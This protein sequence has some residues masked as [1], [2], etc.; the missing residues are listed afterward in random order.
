[1]TPTPQ[2]FH[3]LT[4]EEI[5]TAL[6][7]VRAR[8]EKTLTYFLLAHFAF[9][10]AIA[11]VYDTWRITIAAG[12]LNLLAFMATVRLAPGT[13]LARIVSGVALQIFVAL[14]IYQFHGLAEMHFFF[15]TSFAAMIAYLDWV[16]MWPATLFIIV[17]HVAFA[18]LHNSGVQLYFFEDSYVG[19]TKLGMHF[20]IGVVHVT[21][22]GIWAHSLR[23]RALRDYAE[24]RD[25]DA[26]VRERT[27]ELSRTAFDLRV[28]LDN[29][30][31]GFVSVDRNGMLGPVHSEAVTAWFGRK[32]E[33]ERFID[34]VVSRDARFARAFELGLEA[35]FEDVLP[36]ELTLDQLPARMQCGDRIISVSYKLLGA[37]SDAGARLVVIL[38][39]CTAETERA[40]AE[41][42]QRDLVAAIDR[43]LR[44]KAGFLEFFSESSEL[45][46]RLA[47]GDGTRFLDEK[48]DLHTL[49]GNTAIYGL[50]A[51]SSFCHELENGIEL[52]GR[53]SL[54]TNARLDLAQR[55][56]TFSKQLR[57]LLDDSA[58][59]VLEVDDEEWRH[60]IDA[61][62]A[63][64]PRQDLLRRIR[65]WKLE[66]TKKRLARV[67]GQAAH[68]AGRLGRA[69]VHVEIEDGSL[70]LDRE[71]WASFWSAFVHVVRNALDHGI[72]PPEKRLES[73]KQAGGTL[74][75]VTRMEA[76]SLVISLT[77]DGAGVDWER[78]AT[79][80]A[81][82]G[83]PHAT[84][85]DRVRALFV[86]GLS[87]RDEIT[88]TSGR[89]VGMA[90]FARE[91]EARGGVVEVASQRG[92]GTT[93]MLRFPAASAAATGALALTE[94]LPGGASLPV[95][96]NDVDA[97]R[98][99]A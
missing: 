6:A 27:A 53:E 16:A 59:P 55:W 17:Q 65:G 52:D 70:R 4:K 86:D 62:A 88:E 10:L 71:A 60:I 5:S 78:V 67:A 1:M 7:P 82:R 54:S 51:L 11:P 49:K 25:L 15:F 24:N 12:G 66:P 64:A 84:D 80:A 57:L 99:S 98:A 37:P 93:F 95:P 85:E 83:L 18:L 9:A 14:H 87:T 38:T 50:A 44:D 90:G 77:D 92:A 48:R 56:E 41:A 33:S 20:G 89:G 94:L 26:K 69:P 34:W 79:K 31:Q 36:L 8:A 97:V 13:F 32:P 58:I 76:G 72:E 28:L 3:A 30:G 91:V 47:T 75:L 42:S 22:C 29:V 96:D 19:V 23:L 39:D 45:V 81:E 74:R 68:I 43:I 73:G 46:R 40:R 63:G 2:L 35:L 21:L 61:I